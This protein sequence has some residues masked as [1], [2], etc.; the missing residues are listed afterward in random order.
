M[1]ILSICFECIVG[2]TN[3]LRGMAPTAC[4]VWHQLTAGVRACVALTA[5]MVSARPIPF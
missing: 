4:E 1:W 5:T 2:G 3:C